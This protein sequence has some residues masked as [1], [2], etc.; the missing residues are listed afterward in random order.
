MLSSQVFVGPFPPLHAQQKP[1]GPFVSHRYD[2]VPQL[3]SKLFGRMPAQVMAVLSLSTSTNHTAM[4]NTQEIFCLRRRTVLTSFFRQG[5]TIA[6]LQ[7]S[8]CH[9]SVENEETMSWSTYQDTKRFFR[10]KYPLGWEHVNKQGAA[11]FL[12]DPKDFRAQIGVTVAPIKIGSLSEFGSVR[13]VGERLLKAESMKESTVPGG[14]HMLSES[15]RNGEISGIQFYDYEYIVTTTRGNKRVLSSVT[16]EKGMLYILNVQAG[17]NE[18]GQ[19]IDGLKPNP[20]AQS[21]FGFD[22]GQ[23]CVE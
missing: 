10:V 13:E 4:E 2:A 12:R 9:A 8:S 16:V 7:L 14:V 1:T 23:N 11:L 19:A 3:K 15:E 21:V 17:E 6:M 18:N 22:V 5:L 20:Y